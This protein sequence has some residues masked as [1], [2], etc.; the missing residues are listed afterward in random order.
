M[1][2]ECC[3]WVAGCEWP[4]HGKPG[5]RSSCDIAQHKAH[6]SLTVTCLSVAW[7]PGAAVCLQFIA[8]SPSLFPEGE[9]PAIHL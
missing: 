3:W 1:M 5:W 4:R 7:L 9:S 8:S 2:H 6:C